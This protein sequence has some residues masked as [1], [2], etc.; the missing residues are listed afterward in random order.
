MGSTPAAGSPKETCKPRQP[1]KLLVDRGDVCNVLFLAK[2]TVEAHGY[3]QM[4][5]SRK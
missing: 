5:D 4:K 3:L 2:V 1:L